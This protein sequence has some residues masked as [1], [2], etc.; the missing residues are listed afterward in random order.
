MNRDLMGE[1]I[2]FTHTISK[3]TEI[4]MDQKVTRHPEYKAD[5]QSI[6]MLIG[7]RTLPDGVTR[8]YYTD[9]PEFTRTGST[10]ALLVVPDA[11]RGPIYVSLDGAFLLN[12]R[13]VR[14]VMNED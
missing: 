4:V 12:G 10:R 8:K 7:I 9:Y 13:S 11:Y 1:W 3:S 2:T 14:D 6:G 5:R